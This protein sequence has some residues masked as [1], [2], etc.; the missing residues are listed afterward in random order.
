MT[1]EEI[2]KNRRENQYAVFVNPF[3]RS[4]VTKTHTPPIVLPKLPMQLHTMQFISSEDMIEVRYDVVYQ[5]DYTLI[6][7]QKPQTEN[8]GE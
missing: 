5:D 8:K 7:V 6:A 3:N 4:V 2:E 1:R